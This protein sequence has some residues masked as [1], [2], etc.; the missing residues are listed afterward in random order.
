[1]VKG[2]F[3]KVMVRGGFAVRVRGV[4]Y[5]SKQVFEISETDYNARPWVFDLVK[6]ETPAVEKP[7]PVVTV[8]AVA[9]EDVL[10]TAIASPIVRRGRAGR[11][12]K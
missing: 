2:V 5:Q 10:N 9:A 12:K 11:G 7:E 6:E 8:A 3:M 4:D 1:M